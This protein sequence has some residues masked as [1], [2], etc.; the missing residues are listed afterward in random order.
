MNIAFPTFPTL[1]CF[2]TRSD[3]EKAQLF[4]AEPPRILHSAWQHASQL[5]STVQRRTCWSG[6]VV[7]SGQ[8]LADVIA[9]LLQA[10]FPEERTARLRL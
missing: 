1:Q 6:G 2:W 5:D 8:D 3:L 9:A 4:A 10:R 7:F